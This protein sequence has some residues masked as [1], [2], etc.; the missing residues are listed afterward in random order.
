MHNTKNHPGSVTSR[1]NET[2]LVQ[3]P[4][5]VKIDGKVTD[6]SLEDSM[7][8]LAGLTEAIE[9]VG[10]TEKKLKGDGTNYNLLT[11]AKP[12]SGM[13]FLQSRLG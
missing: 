5:S 10:Q 9:R 11:L 12:G 6:L 4:I 8:L 3:E 7:L 2:C 13:S 1:V